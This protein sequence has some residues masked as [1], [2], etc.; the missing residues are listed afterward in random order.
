MEMAVDIAIGICDGIHHAH[1]KGI[2]HRDIKPHNIL[3]TS[4]GIVKVVISG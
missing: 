2:I 1:S 4:D 3:I